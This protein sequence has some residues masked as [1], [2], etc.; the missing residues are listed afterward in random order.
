MI[1]HDELKRR[2]DFTAWHG[3]NALP[4][5]LLLWHYRLRGSELPGWQVRAARLLALPQAGRLQ[6]SV[7]QQRGALRDEALRVDAYEYPSREAAHE[8]LIHLLGEFT[9]PGMTRLTDVGLGDVTF[10]GKDT[11]ALLFARANLVFLV[12]GSGAA[13][14]PVMPLAQALDQDIIAKPAVPARAAVAAAPRAAQRV[15]LGASVAVA[16]GPL[17]AAARASVAAVGVAGAAAEP[18]YKPF[19]QDCDLYAE[20]DEVRAAPRHTGRH[21][22]EIYTLGA[23]ES[24]DQ[25]EL[26]IEAV[27]T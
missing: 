23:G 16:L 19:S 22:V 6:P 8:A 14:V 27:K 13:A 10:G 15:T 12:A 4:L 18:Q 17:P 3:I 1:M 9:R 2:H 24:W 5:H 25:R 26:A 7:W 11:R 20:H 21:A